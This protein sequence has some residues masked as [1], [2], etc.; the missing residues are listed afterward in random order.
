M[1][2]HLSLLQV[3]V[4]SN[5]ISRLFLCFS[6]VILCC[7]CV[8]IKLFFTSNVAERCSPPPTHSCDKYLLVTRRLSLPLAMAGCR[9]DTLPLDTY[10][11]ISK[12]VECFP[13]Q[14]FGKIFRRQVCCRIVHDP[15]LPIIHLIF[16]QEIPNVKVAD[17]LSINK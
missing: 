8:S 2:I 10:H 14:C 15:H 17:S 13:L 3:Q 4:F 16:N 9:V 11:F 1:D 12:L 7:C 5:L 6:F